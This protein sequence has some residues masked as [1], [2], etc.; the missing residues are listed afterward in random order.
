PM[1]GEG[2][3]AR[4]AAESAAAIRADKC[5]HVW[6]EVINVRGESMVRTVTALKDAGFHREAELLTHVSTDSSAWE[7]YNRATFL[8]HANVHARTPGK[9]RFLT[10]PKKATADWWAAHVPRGAVLLGKAAPVSP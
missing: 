1:D 10:Y 4:F 7:A 3:Y 6:A 8:A 5:E 9:L 2:A